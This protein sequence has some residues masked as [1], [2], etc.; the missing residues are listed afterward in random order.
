MRLS[1]TTFAACLAAAYSTGATLHAQVPPSPAPDL[2]VVSTGAPDGYVQDTQNNY[3]YGSPASPQPYPLVWALEHT[4][5]PGG[6]GPYG[7]TYGYHVQLTA[8]TYA[9][10]KFDT[11]STSA[12]SV[13]WIGSSNASP[14]IVQGGAGV[15]I[16]R[17]TGPGSD[18]IF[19]I[20]GGDPGHPFNFI[21]W[22]D[23][24]IEASTRAGVL[25]GWGGDP[26]DEVAYTG[27]TFENCEIDGDFD[28]AAQS[29]PDSK[30][31]MLTWAL[32]DFTWSGGSV[33]NIHREHCFYMHNNAGDVLIEDADLY[34]VGRTALQVVARKWEGTPQN[35][36]L[37]P[38][39]GDITLR[40]CVIADTGL[41]NA[42]INPDSG[43][44]Y[45]S[46]FHHG[47]S[48]TIVGRQLGTSTVTG[49]RIEYGL[50]TFTPG[51]RAAIVARHDYPPN[52]PYGNGAFHAW[53]TPKE[54]FEQSTLLILHSNRITYNATGC[55]YKPVVVGAFL[56]ACVQNNFVS[57]GSKPD[58][59]E[60]GLVP[61]SGQPPWHP[62][63]IFYQ[64][65]GNVCLQGS[66]APGNIL[67]LDVPI[68]QPYTNQLLCP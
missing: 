38:N 18:T 66:G 45:S 8:G 35:P 20:S 52:T 31:G 29:G 56:F 5:T 43:L 48:V 25:I 62:A 50:D 39:P 14:V 23:I 41:F 54:D 12:P 30:W 53:T 40:D 3:L 22:R 59:I 68:Q 37:P 34:E 13:N 51:L 27:W 15:V 9:P 60:V 6:S 67:F 55:D 28:H 11:G 24:F 33:H 58:A 65:E 32:A 17:S 47:Q 42:G 2:V 61:T 21:T 4:G 64:I 16:E 1:A 49:N 19:V 44:P 36:V 63:P 46:N 57:S 10:F 26:P 7:P